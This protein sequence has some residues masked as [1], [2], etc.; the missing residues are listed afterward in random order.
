MQE[1]LTEELATGLQ[2]EIDAEAVLVE[3]RATHLCEAMCRIKTATE[4]TTMSVEEKIQQTETRNSSEIRLKHTADSN[5]D[6]Q[7]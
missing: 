1:T 7:R 4:T 3:M 2:Q 6:N 5:Y